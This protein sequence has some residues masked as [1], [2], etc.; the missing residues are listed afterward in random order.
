MKNA[1][2]ISVTETNPEQNNQ[3]QEVMLFDAVIHDNLAELLPR[4]TDRL[5]LSADK[6]QAFL[7]GLKL[8]G[9]VIMTE[10]S[11]PLMRDLAPH[12]RAIMQVVKPAR[13]T[14]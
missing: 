7:L 10:R 9:E 3:L 2:R 14:R 11:H 5:E 13:S 4:V 6:S 8:L 12:F 1:Y